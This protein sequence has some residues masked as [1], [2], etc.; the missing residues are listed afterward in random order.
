MATA[1]GS[2]SSSSS[3]TT[4]AVTTAAPGG[5]PASGKL[6]RHDS[7][8]GKPLAA[9]GPGGGTPGSAGGGLRR[10]YGRTLEWLQAVRTM[11]KD[12]P[13]TVLGLSS[14][15]SPK[16]ADI[17]EQSKILCEDYVYWRLLSS[18]TVSDTDRDAAVD[19][20]ADVS[21]KL[22]DVSREIQLIGARLESAYPQLYQNVSRQVN[23]PLR[24]EATVRRTLSSVADFL[25]KHGAVTWVRIVA[26]LAVSGA[27][28]VE[29]VQAGN[30]ELIAAV[31]TIVPDLVERHLATWISRQGGW[32]E[33]MKAFR[34]N[35]DT[36]NLW[37]LTGLGTVT[38]LVFT[39]MTAMQI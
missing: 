12:S 34:L 32:V 36:R 24:S 2:S 5:Q 16:I 1:N 22:S 4:A 20:A 28:A 19:A 38:G 17:I 21:G 18:G 37:T 30:P 14:K 31:V 25:F 8:D 26:L 3:T 7:I 27:V 9:A 39:W 23:L 13:L 35:K 15:Q 10:I 29:C 6:T 11:M 33:I